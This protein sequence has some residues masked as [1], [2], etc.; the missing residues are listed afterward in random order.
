MK[1]MGWK[2]EGQG[3]G[4]DNQGIAAPLV[5]QKTGANQATIVQ[6]A[7]REAPAQAPAAKQAKAAPAKPRP[8]SPVLMLQNMS[9]RTM[10]TRTCRRRRPKRRRSMARSSS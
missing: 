1:K 9:V 4:K 10:W 5:M 8:P 6:G 2:G 7:K 3:L